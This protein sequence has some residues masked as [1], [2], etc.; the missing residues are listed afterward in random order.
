MIRVEFNSSSFQLAVIV[1]MG[2]VSD[3]VA[4]QPELVPEAVSCLKGLFC[5]KSKSLATIAKCLLPFKKLWEVHFKN[6]CF[7]DYLTVEDS[8]VIFHELPDVEEVILMQLQTHAGVRHFFERAQGIDNE[9][10]S[11]VLTMIVVKDIFKGIN[12][13]EKF[14]DTIPIERIFPETIW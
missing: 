6:V 10:A 2:Q 4:A 9:A 12:V 1:W 7:E 11:F 13:V 14:L 5:P 8:S 3:I